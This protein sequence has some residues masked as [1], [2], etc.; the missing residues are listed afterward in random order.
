MR[1]HRHVTRESTV[2]L[3][4]GTVITWYESGSFDTLLFQVNT[5]P[6]FHA[7]VFATRYR[8]CSGWHEFELSSNISELKGEAIRLGNWLSCDC[9]ATLEGRRRFRKLHP[10][11]AGITVA[12]LR[13]H[14]PPYD[15]VGT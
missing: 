13:L 1:K 15:Y 5:A 10:E 14:G 11:C 12:K 3:P 7:A 8:L 4:R 9:F 6:V 2:D